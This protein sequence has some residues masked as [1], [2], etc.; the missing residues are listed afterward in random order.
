MIK[1]FQEANLGAAS[2][3]FNA[4]DFVYRLKK[5]QKLCAKLELNAIL[6]IN[7]VDSRNNGE[8]VKLTNWLFLGHSGLAVE[9]N[10][11]L[12][13]EFSEL[14]AL[15]RP[16]SVQLYIEP[17]GLESLKGLLYAVPNLD[18]FCPSK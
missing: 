10:N 11:F 17:E 8:C 7:G 15:V 16:A 3:Q 18:V 1:F 2:P 6:I 14:V 13:G 12:S 9:S 5:L 4:F